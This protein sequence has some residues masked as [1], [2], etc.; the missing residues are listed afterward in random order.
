MD[1]SKN[2]GMDFTTQ[3]WMGLFII[4]KAYEEMDDLFFFPLFLE[5]PYISCMFGRVHDH[6]TSREGV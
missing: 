4:G 1:V 2:R 6:D 3:Q 5:T